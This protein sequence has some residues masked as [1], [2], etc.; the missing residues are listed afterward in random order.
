MYEPFDYFVSLF[1]V[2]RLSKHVVNVQSEKSDL[3]NELTEWKQRFT[4]LKN[5][6]QAM[7]LENESKL[8]IPEHSSAINEV[9][10]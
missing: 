3:E 8:T 7:L 4:G 6:H 1:P 9:K 2:S 10:K 5:K